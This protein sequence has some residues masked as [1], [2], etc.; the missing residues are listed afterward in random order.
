MEV[1]QHDPKIVVTTEATSKDKGQR[2]L[3]QYQMDLKDIERNVMD[4]IQQLVGDGK[5]RVTVSAD[6][7]VKEFG[8]GASAMCSVSLTCNQDLQTI[9]QAAKLAG[10]LARD[11]A[12]EQ[13]ARADMELQAVMGSNR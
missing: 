1:F 3:A 7:G 12:Q 10:D 13:R 9:E 8:T 11:I 5:A 4:Q 2:I 6:F